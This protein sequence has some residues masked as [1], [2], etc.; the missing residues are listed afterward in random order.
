M[1]NTN[2]VAAAHTPVGSTGAGRSPT[3]LTVLP[4]R[5]PAVERSGVDPRDPYVERYWLAVLG[6]STVLL[7]RRF[8]RGLEERPDGFRVPLVDTS[9]VLGLGRGTGSRSP[10]MRT[11]DR[12]E[13][14][15][16]LRRT[17]PGAVEVRTR[18]PLLSPRQIRHL[19]PVMRQLHVDWV[20]SRERT[21]D[22]GR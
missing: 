18:M 10:I 14:F 19:P 6:P 11:I 9:V 8:A 4:W 5:D 22:P 3:H 1:T 7:L 20:R 12:A 17:G 13:K 2:L 21:P 16:M 15:G